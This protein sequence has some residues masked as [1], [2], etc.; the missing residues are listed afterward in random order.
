MFGCKPVSRLGAGRRLVL[1][2]IVVGVVI[3]TSAFAAE[4][5]APPSSATPCPGAASTA[6]A[7]DVKLLKVVNYYPRNR[8]WTAM[9]TDW[10]PEVIDQDFRALQAMGANTVRVSLFPGTFGFPA[11]RA[12]FTDRLRQV[13]DMAGSHG[14]RVQLTLFDWFGRFDDISGSESWMESVLSPYRMDSR[15]A[16]VEMANEVDPG[17]AVF[18]TW[19]RALLLAV[20]RVLPAVP[21]TL[22]VKDNTAQGDLPRLVQEFKGTSLDLVTVHFYGPAAAVDGFIRRAMA[23]ACPKPIFIGEAGYSL[24]R[25]PPEA[26]DVAEYGQAAFFGTVFSAAARY[27]LALPAPWTMNDFQ[28]RA[29]P[30]S[31]GQQMIEYYFGLLRLDGTARPAVQV[32]REWFLRGGAAVDR[33]LSFD[34]ASSDGMPVGWRPVFRQYGDVAF[35]S[36]VGRGR[37]GSVRLAHSKAMSD[38]AVGVGQLDALPVTAGQLCRAAVWARGYRATGVNVAVLAWYDEDGRFIR[39]AATA[40]IPTG[41]SGWAQLQVSAQAPPHSASVE[42]VLKSIADSGTVWFDDASLSVR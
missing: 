42:V 22:S 9:W 8:P 41:T 26:S 1:V 11:A 2:A 3:G 36:S 16:L 39:D 5:S 17:N 31:F 10:H 19:A 4:W 6:A 24:F 27:G 28:P 40:R 20:H 32:V 38:G 34:A 37:P 13:L 33:H 7:R 18:V 29:I 23:V 15:I 21:V 30:G 14:L 25:N 12:D 35:D